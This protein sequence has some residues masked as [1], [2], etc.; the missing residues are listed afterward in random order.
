MIEKV[1]GK[2]LQISTK[3]ISRILSIKV[4]AHTQNLRTVRT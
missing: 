3:A 4:D 2:R 1:S